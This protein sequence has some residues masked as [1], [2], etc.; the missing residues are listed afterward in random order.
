[1]TSACWKFKAMIVEW[2]E[3]SFPVAGRSV[4]VKPEI[5]KCCFSETMLTSAQRGVVTG[6]DLSTGIVTA[7]FG[8][9]EVAIPPEQQHAVLYGGPQKWSSWK[10][11]A[12]SKFGT[13]IVLPHCATDIKVRF[14]VKT[15][16]GTMPVCEWD[17]SAQ[18]W[19][20]PS[21]FKHGREE[22]FFMPNGI[23]LDVHFH[24][25][26]RGRK[27]HVTRAWNAALS[28]EMGRGLRCA[29]EFWPSDDPKAPP[30]APR[31]LPKTLAAAIQYGSDLISQ[32]KAA[33]EALV[34]SGAALFESLQS[35]NLRQSKAS[36]GI[37]S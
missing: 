30:P 24:L 29:W 7:L 37:N 19:V 28:D 3:P 21:W 26:S 10:D 16:H 32:R 1:M 23:P 35:L 11:P 31:S 34:E 2:T 6:L 15:A 17:R 12:S 9:S 33:A 14:K 8:Q 5:G 22:I 4:C 20:E 25:E 18:R 27:C 13:V 36:V